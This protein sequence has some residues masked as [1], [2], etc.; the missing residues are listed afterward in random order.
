MAMD[1]ERAMGTAIRPAMGE[2]RPVVRAQPLGRLAE[3]LGIHLDGVAPPVLGIAHDSRRVIPGDLFVAL[4]GTRIDGADYLREAV[5]R[6]AVAGCVARDA[7]GRLGDVGIPLL[8]VSDPR[9]ALARLASAFHDH[10]ARCL[11]LVGVTGTLG[12]TSTALLV[13]AAL[14]ASGEDRSVGVIGS[15]GARVAGLAAARVRAGALPHLDGM[16]TPDPPALHRALRAM[17]DAGVPLVAMEVTSHALAQRRVEELGFALGIFTNLVPDEHLE[18]HATPE[19]YLRTKARFLDHLRP[20][21]PLV[22]NADDAL[23]VRTVEQAAARTPRPLVGVSLGTSA[24]ALGAG[25]VASDPA[26][27]VE[28]LRGDA[29]GSTFSLHVRR[30]LPRLEVAGGGTVAPC[31]VPIALPVLGVQQV[32]NAALAATAALVAGATSR[33]VTEALAEM[34]PMRR[35]MNVVRSDGP[36]VVDDT[37]GH[38]D[39]LRA[40]FASVAGIPHATL[41]VLFGVRGMRGPAI[42]ER[43]GRALGETV[44]AQAQRGAVELV[45]TSAD[46]A[47]DA[48]NRVQAGERDAFLAGLAAVGVPC[49]HVR[50]LDD[51]VRAVLRGCGATDLVLLLGTQGM[52]GAATIALDELDRA[53]V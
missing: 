31:I 47:S 14:A 43:L 18:F 5:A 32:A 42:N 19:D 38:P 39:T 26:V 17:A 35:R 49:R 33:G 41:R 29:G 20:G 16:T 46:E 51:A 44:R 7:L 10:P 53:H 21:A 6:G 1:G 25:H 12:K 27:C 24:A 23:V 37:T 36:V 52:D 2:G 9:A 22:H 4:P 48:R 50:R 28:S 11:T 15:L 34:S 3:A 40:V 30:P 45:V 13:Q 8:P